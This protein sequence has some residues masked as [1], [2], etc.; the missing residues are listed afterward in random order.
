V[1]VT[2]KKYIWILGLLATLVISYLMARIT[3]LYI[4]GYFP[5]TLITASSTSSSDKK[6]L[7]Q[8][9]KEF[10]INV[11]LK[12]NFFD[13]KETEIKTDSPPVEIVEDVKDEVVPTGEAV[14]T[15]MKI[16]LISTVSVG[17]GQNPYS[18]A[19]IKNGKEIGT[20]TIDGDKTFAPKV[21]IVSI[22]PGRV[23][24]INEKR[25]EYVLLDD[26]VTKK[27]KT[28]TK[29]SFTDK[30]ATRVT[31]SSEEITDITADGDVI[32]IPR[33][34][35]DQ[36]LNQP[37]RLYTDMRAVPFYKEG[38][39]SGFK[40]LS[41]KRGSLFEKLGLKRGDILKSVNG[42]VLEI[43]TGFQTFNT[44]KSE[45]EF[46]LEFERRGEEKTQRYEIVG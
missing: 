3:S 23:E 39:A 25:L 32:K 37:D 45:S 11:I 28:P 33:S 15:K 44:L 22:L 38:K 20:Y 42:K 6:V 43:A 7:E 30:I 4:E 14:L 31:K 16:N 2:L 36:A 46:V 17:N 34:I 5:S 18:S 10:D 12:R 24:F 13:E 8:I 26:F 27:G 21:K 35:I 9:S 1:G 19:V 41:V 29:T 40:I